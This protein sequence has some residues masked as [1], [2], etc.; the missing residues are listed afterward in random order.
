MQILLF[1]IIIII[2]FFYIINNQGT[3]Q[4]PVDLKVLLPDR[5]AITVTIRKNSS[6]TDVYDAIIDKI[7]LSKDLAS[8]FA[9][10]EIVEHGFER[11]LQPN[12]FPYNLYIQ[13]IQN[14]SAASTCLTVKKWFFNIDTELKLSSNNLLE[15][16][17]FYQVRLFA[18][19]D[20][21]N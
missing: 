2:C 21:F 1:L 13:N 6:T 9:I 17:F 10:F 11:K 8:Y 7:S 18:L 5:T 14:T 3:N 16:F 4:A 20:V 12:E 15:T 19:L